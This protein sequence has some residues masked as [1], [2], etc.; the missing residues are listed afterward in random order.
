MIED[1]KLGSRTLHFASGQ[2]MGVLCIREWGMPGYGGWQNLA[3][4][5]G[6]ISIPA[7][8]ESMLKLNWG[9]SANLNPLGSLGPNDLQWLDCRDTQV[10]DEQL[11]HIRGLTGLHDLGLGHT[12]VGDAGLRHIRDMA[13]IRELYLASTKI[14]SD[15]L[16]HLA[17]LNSLRALA[18]NDTAIG[19]EALKGIEGLSKL[20]R[21][22][23]KGTRVTD[24]CIASLKTL[25]GLNRLD[26]RETAMTEQGLENLKK[27]LPHCYIVRS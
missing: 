22:W 10:N 3:E 21:L 11:F 4:A 20:R 17:R 18:L 9:A 23:I 5:R 8:K 12:P 26:I 24:A 13:A 6:S 15:G 1:E 19:D 16:R 27:S 14:T 2:S 25:G 7:G